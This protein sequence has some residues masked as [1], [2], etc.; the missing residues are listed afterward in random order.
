[1]ILSRYRY[2]PVTVT[3]PSLYS[4]QSSVTDRYRFFLKGYRQ[5]PFVTDRDTIVTCVTERYMR[6]RTL[7]ALPNATCVTERYMRYRTLQAL[8]SVTERYRTLQNITERYRTL[9]TEFMIFRKFK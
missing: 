2:R 1:M 7:H 4:L 5:L 6:Y 9:H 3:L 8:Q